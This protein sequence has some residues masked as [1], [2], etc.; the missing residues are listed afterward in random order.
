M[1]LNFFWVPA[2]DSSAAEQELNA[3]LSRHRIIQVEKQFL[4]APSQPGW[5]VSVQWVAGPGGP[6]PHAGGK[7]GKVDYREILDAP[8]FQLFAALRTWRKEA[9]TA[10]GVPPYSVATNEQLAEIARRRV[11]SR[12]ALEEVDGCGSGRMDRYAAALLEVCRR[13][14]AALPGN[15]SAQP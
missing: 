3:F 1:R 11:Q 8:T 2:W 6:G 12:A 15:G 4:P 14:I 5:A 10:G 13:E 9:A 7:L